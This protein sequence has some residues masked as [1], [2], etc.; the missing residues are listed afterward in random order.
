MPTRLQ[1]A[2]L[3]GLDAL[4]ISAHIKTT[5]PELG[6]ALH[7]EVVAVEEQLVD[8]LPAVDGQSELFLLTRDELHA[9]VSRGV[10]VGA[11]VVVHEVGSRIRQGDNT[12]ELLALDATAAAS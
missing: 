1:E 5:A 7:R 6:D 12:A 9:V 10:I 4:E 2:P 3:S 11:G 8:E